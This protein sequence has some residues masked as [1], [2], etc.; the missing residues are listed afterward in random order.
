MARWMAI[1]ARLVWAMQSVWVR[2][3]AL[4]GNPVVLDENPS[5]LIKVVLNGSVPL[6]TQGTPDAYRMPQFRPQLSDE[7]AADVITFMRKCWSNQA[8]AVTT[9]QVAKLRKTTNP[10]NDQVIIL[11]MR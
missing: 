4:A 10:T 7:D 5:S 11:K 3:T 6:V 2:L 1:G 8:P 9:A